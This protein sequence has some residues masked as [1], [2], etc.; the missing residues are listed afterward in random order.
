[1]GVLPL[2]FHFGRE[3]IWRNTENNDSEDGATFDSVESTEIGNLS[4][5]I[6]QTNEDAG[7]LRDDISDLSAHDALNSNLAEGNLTQTEAGSNA[8]TIRQSLDEERLQSEGTVNQD[9]NRPEEENSD[10]E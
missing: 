5:K 8:S 7:N 9:N 3:R 4:L 2:H 10:D 6:T 1:M